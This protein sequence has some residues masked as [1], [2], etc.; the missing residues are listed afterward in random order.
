[1]LVDNSPATN[2]LNLRNVIVRGAVIDAPFK[3]GIVN[4]LVI[5]FVSNKIVN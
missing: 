1:M 5:I 4:K 3:A 2:A